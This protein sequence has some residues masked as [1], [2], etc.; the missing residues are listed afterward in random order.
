MPDHVAGVTGVGAGVIKGAPF[1]ATGQKHAH[2]DRRFLRRSTFRIP[3]V[4]RKHR[5]GGVGGEDFSFAVG[6]ALNLD[7][8][9]TIVARGRPQAG[10]AHRGVD[11]VGAVDALAVLVTR[12]GV[13][14]LF[15]GKL[16]LERAFGHP[17]RIEDVP[18]HDL[19]IRL[20][21]GFLEHEL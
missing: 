20:I 8:N 17:Q 5:E 19:R 12:G 15:G 10:G 3:N 1:P 14:G 11:A 18:F 4:R 9:L 2:A 21:G 16:E 13:R 6:G 7:H